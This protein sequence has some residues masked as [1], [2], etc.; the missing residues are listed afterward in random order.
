MGSIVVNRIPF[1]SNLDDP[2]PLAAAP[3]LG[4]HTREIA[5]SLLDM[6]EAEYADHVAREVFV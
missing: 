5:Q 6:S 1:I 3:L 2:G 4:E